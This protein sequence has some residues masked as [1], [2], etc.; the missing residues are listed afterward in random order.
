MGIISRLGDTKEKSFRSAT[1]SKSSAEITAKLPEIE[2]GLYNIRCNK[3]L[4]H[5]YEQIK[6]EV[7]DL[8]TKY[9]IERIGIIV[10][11]SNSGIEEIHNAVDEKLT[12][13]EFPKNFDYR[14]IEMG[15]PANYLQKISGLGGV[16][17]A[18]ST[19]CSSSAKAFSSARRLIENDICDAVLVGGTDSLCRFTEAGF[20]SLEAVSDSQTNPFS[21]NRDGINLGE[22]AGLF[23]LDKTAGKQGITLAGI[24]ESSDAYHITAPHPEGI[25]ATKAMQKALDDAGLKTSDINYANLHGTGTIHNDAMEAHAMEAVFPNIPCSSTKPLTGHCLGASGIIELGLCWLT[26]SDYNKNQELIPHV[27]DKNYDENIPKL[28]LVGDKNSSKNIKNCASSSFAFGGS[29]VCVII[30]KDD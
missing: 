20:G 15:N 7:S 23:I 8:K 30:G 24:G 19:A 14:M 28:N 21:K 4:Q 2:D 27:Y 25:G 9:G 26:L 16:R 6:T 11:T 3:L 17:Y 1:F 5:C 10:G 22:G 29:N 18:I 13:G 12:H